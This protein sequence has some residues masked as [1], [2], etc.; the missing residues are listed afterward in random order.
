MQPDQPSQTA[1]YMALF[2]AIES[3][4]PPTRRLFSDPFS[5]AFL[6]PPLHLAAD[7]ARLPLLGK[8]IAWIIDRR[9]PG[10]RPSGVARTRLIDDLLLRALHDGVQQV[11]IL[12]AGF[13]CR[14]YR[15][16]GMNQVQVIE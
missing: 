6:R 8:L 13:D 7:V 4:Q 12:G 11:V 3:V 9:W 14:A 15:L 10:A 1:E 2:R 16:K 5:R